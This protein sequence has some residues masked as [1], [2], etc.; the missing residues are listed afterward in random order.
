MPFMATV[1]RFAYTMC[2]AERLADLVRKALK[3]E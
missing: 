2:K 1:I 3:Q